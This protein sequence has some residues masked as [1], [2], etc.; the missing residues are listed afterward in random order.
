MK[1][2][3]VVAWLLLR[4]S[5][6]A[7]LAPLRLLAFLPTQARWRAA[8]LRVLADQPALPDDDPQVVLMPGEARTGRLFI[9]A[10]EASGD[11][12]AAAA[13]RAVAAA[14]GHVEWIG[15]GGAPLTDAGVAL[16]YPLSGRAVMG[17][18]GVFRSLPFVLGAVRRFL[19]VL[20]DERPDLVVLV[21]YPGLHLVLARLARR[22]GIPVLHYI[23]P[24][25]WAWGPWRMQRYRRCVSATLTILPFESP[26]F[27][28]AGIPSCYVGH[29]LL[30]R[31]P[32]APAPDLPPRVLCLLPGS[33]RREI[34]LNLP[35]LLRVAAALREDDPELTVVLPHSDPARG[36]LIESLLRDHHAEFVRYRKGPIGAVLATARLVLAKSGTGSL[37]ACLHGTPTVVVYRL[38]GRFAAWFAR[39]C[40]TV[41]FIAS[42]NLIA[43]RAV[44]P[45][46]CFRG[47]DG[48]TDVL[49]AARTLWPDGATRTRCLDD[50][51]AVRA[52]LGTA[53]ASRRVARWILPFCSPPTPLR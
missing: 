37:E 50:L 12:H 40:L 2:R 21:D 34:E 45:E 32:D 44:I 53:G 8:A 10:G 29:P 47:D 14:G 35:G 7:M 3:L 25:Y 22:R 51:R 24:Q 30:D 11:A 31:A 52:R 39:R 9:S 18:S 26:F 38:S 43:G 27:R 36:P 46:L 17:L 15:F 28:D 19:Q 4:E 6:R 49:A 48:W 1:Y 42:A 16:R 5:V 33:R 41:P 13:V 23:A 20:D